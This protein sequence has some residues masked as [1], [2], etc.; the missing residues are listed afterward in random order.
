MPQITPFARAALIEFLVLSLFTGQM[1]KLPPHG[2]SPA[3]PARAPGGQRV[4]PRPGRLPCLLPGPGWPSLTP[5]APPGPAP[6]GRP[7][8]PEPG[9]GPTGGGRGNLGSGTRGGIVPAPQQAPSPSPQ[10]FPERWRGQGTSR[11]PVIPLPATLAGSGRPIAAPEG[12]RG[13]QRCLPRPIGQEESR[14]KQ[15]TNTRIC[16]CASA[17]AAGTRL[18]IRSPTPARCEPQLGREQ[19]AEYGAWKGSGRHGDAEARKT[20]SHTSGAGSPER[21]A[22]SRQQINSNK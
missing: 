11:P 21:T 22:T 17:G 7:P 16:A 13:S 12:D 1:S 6:L 19:R 2:T 3:G 9:P 20:P 10:P 18:C 8:A 4:P 15:V 5:A 14:G